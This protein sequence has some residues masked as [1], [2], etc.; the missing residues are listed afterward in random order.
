[1]LA[2]R[3]LFTFSRKAISLKTSNQQLAQILQTEKFN[4][5]TI[6][7]A[8]CKSGIQL[9]KKDFKVCPQ[10]FTEVLTAVALFTT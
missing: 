6:E 3:L 7:Y 1:M 10:H 4:W 9:V 8:C 2:N 5:M